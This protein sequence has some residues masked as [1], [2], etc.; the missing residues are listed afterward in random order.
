MNL[1]FLVEGEKT[2]PRIYNS[3]LKFFF[4]DIQ[5][6]TRPED[7]VG[8]TFRII[9]G[10]GYPQVLVR[11][12][13]CILDLKNYSNIDHLIICVDSENEAYQSRF[14]EVAKEISK[15]IALTP[16]LSSVKHKIH[17]IIQHRCIETWA[18]GNNELTGGISSLSPDQKIE[19][20]IFREH[21]DVALKDPEAMDEYPPHRSFGGRQ[22]FH[23]KYLEYYLKSHRLKYSKSDPAEVKKSEYFLALCRRCQSTGHLQS[24][25]KLVQLLEKIKNDN[26]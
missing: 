24:F 5:A 8:N 12:R 7:M 11:I 6:V 20:Q 19:Y 25:Q 26:G 4:P 14:E 9:P 13:G 18:L 16:E 3:W 23:Q 2:E 21:Y 22:K 17:I 15:I 10:Y 1:L